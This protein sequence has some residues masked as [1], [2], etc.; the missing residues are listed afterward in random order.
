[1]T[2]KIND[3]DIFQDR[4]PDPKSL[5]N[6]LHQNGFKAIWMLDPGIKNEGG[7]S[8]IVVQKVM[9]GF[10]KQMEL[11]LLVYLL[12]ALVLNSDS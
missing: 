10:K 12:Y 6:D 2:L 11:L 8:M 9:S 5:V 1:L 3:Y 7:Y 4:F